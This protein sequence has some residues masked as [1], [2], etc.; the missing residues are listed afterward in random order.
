MRGCTALELGAWYAAR[1]A[2]RK[3]AFDC[4]LIS[5]Q[6]NR[7]AFEAHTTWMHR[8]PDEGDLEWVRASRHA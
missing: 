2:G 4:W 1:P 6:F 3:G 7:T 8:V 5:V